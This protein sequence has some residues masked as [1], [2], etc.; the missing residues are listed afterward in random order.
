MLEIPIT[1]KHFLLH[2]VANEKQ[3]ILYAKDFECVRFAGENMLCHANVLLA[4][5]MQSTETR[6][7]STTRAVELQQTLFC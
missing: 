1:Q 4:N 6:W 5:D 3:G 7:K 2:C